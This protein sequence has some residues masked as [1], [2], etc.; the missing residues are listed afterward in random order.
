MAVTEP[1]L[2]GARRR[3][4]DLANM[5]HLARPAI[6]AYELALAAKSDL[7]ERS[8][9]EGDGLQL[10]PARL[11]TQAGPRH[12]DAGYFLRSG[13]RH[14]ELIRQLIDKLTACAETNGAAF[15]PLGVW[16][17]V[18]RDVPRRQAEIALPQ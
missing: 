4:L 6:R 10:P 15:S 9:R 5:L 2:W 16:R 12:A 11:R 3:L 13:R 1:A 7:L 18:E 8:G 17:R 14:A